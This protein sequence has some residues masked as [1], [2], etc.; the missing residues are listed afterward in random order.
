VAE[1][2][3]LI[4]S[5]PSSPLPSATA[6]LCGGTPRHQATCSLA[7]V[8]PSPA[9]TP[10]SSASLSPR[11]ARRRSRRPISIRPSP[12]RAGSP[13]L[14]AVPGVH[15]CAQ[16]SPA[17]RPL[18]PR[19]AQPARGPS[20]ARPSVQRPGHSQLG[21][22]RSCPCPARP[23]N[24]ARRSCLRPCSRDSAPCEALRP[25]MRSAWP[26]R[27]TTQPTHSSSPS[28]ARTSSRREN[29]SSCYCCRCTAGSTSL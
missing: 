19:G 1:I 13:P 21:P 22:W 10:N 28:F 3:G 20:R 7:Q 2:P 14:T 15:G 25:P 11:P 8:R 23:R 9:T 27:A 4:P 12:L 6:S 29:S 17:P 24:V 18:C 26:S 16:V 5:P